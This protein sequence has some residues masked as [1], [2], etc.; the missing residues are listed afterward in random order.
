MMRVAA[1]PPLRQ[2]QCQRPNGAALLQSLPG[3]PAGFLIEVT[4]VRQG[5]PA[6]EWVQ[7][8]AAACRP[9]WRK[10]GNRLFYGNSR[11][12]WRG[13]RSGFLARVRI[14]LRSRNRGFLRWFR[15]SRWF[16]RNFRRWWRLCGGG[17]SRGHGWYGCFRSFRT[18]G[19][20]RRIYRHRRRS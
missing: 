1:V 20:R 8:R 18:C 11:D 9:V 12:F 10:A 14:R 17:R 6:A 2:S 13:F 16:H 19:R 5:A 3:L 15:H 7:D 4:A